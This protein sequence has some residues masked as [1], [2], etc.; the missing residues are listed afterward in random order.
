MR[1]GGG[2][3]LTYREGSI[4]FDNAATTDVYGNPASPHALGVKA[5]RAV[6]TASQKIAGLIGCREEEIIYTSGGTESNNLALLGA[7]EALGKRGGLILTTPYEHPSVLEPLRYLKSKGVFEVIERP[8]SLWQDYLGQNCALASCF[9]VNHET[10][11]IN[12]LGK[13]ASLVKGANS[14]TI[15][16]VDGA[17]GFCKTAMPLNTVDLYSF[18][19]HKFRG[20]A[21]MGG[22]IIKRGTPI[23]PLMFG[24]GQQGALRPGTLNVPG[25][26]ETAEAVEAAFNG[27]KELSEQAEKVKN[28]LASLTAVLKDVFINSVSSDVSPFIL[29]LSFMGVKG[30]TLVNALSARGVYASMGAACRSGKKGASP[31]ELMG[32]EKERAESAVRFSF[33]KNTPT[34]AEAAREEIIKCVTALRNVRQK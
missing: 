33:W 27:L 2:I 4:Y 1:V 11:D 22:L 25:I 14:K 3:A 28:I 32:F 17:Q 5:E 8:V 34:E 30:E 24:G 21:G 6:R 7:A 15:F 12:D 9:H 20:P 13:I 10:G 29:N 26:I 18:S 16:H 23:K 31:L 19:S